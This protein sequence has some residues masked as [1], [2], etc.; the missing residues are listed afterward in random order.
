MGLLG[1]KGGGLGEG[2]TAGLWLGRDEEVLRL[3]LVGI[4]FGDGEDGRWGGQSQSVSLRLA[5]RG[6]H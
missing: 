2:V 5:I 3:L 6:H 1:G 4:L